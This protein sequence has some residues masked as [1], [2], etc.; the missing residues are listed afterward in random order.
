MIN[1]LIFSIITG[2]VSSLII[3]P[4]VLNNKETKVTLPFNRIAAT[5]STAVLCTVIVFVFYYVTNMDR[6][7]TSLW[8]PLLVVTL[9]GAIV[10]GSKDRKLKIVLL[11][12]AIA[13]GAYILSAPLFNAD[14]KYKTVDIVIITVN[15]SFF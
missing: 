9:L 14:Q 7:W 2:V 11:L 4:F 12:G 1:L 8:G 10:A 13:F 5:V 3:V 15:T 6:N